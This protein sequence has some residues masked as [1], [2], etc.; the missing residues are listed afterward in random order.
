MG[1]V[2]LQI[3]LLGLLVKTAVT[4]VVFVEQQHVFCDLE[5]N[6]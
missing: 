1:V 6:L 4:E 5:T 2:M 3:Q